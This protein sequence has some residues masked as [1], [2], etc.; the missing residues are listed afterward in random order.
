MNYISLFSGIEAATCAWHPLGW[1]P[2]CFSE[3]EPFPR[4]VLQ[5]HYPDVVLHG[6]M[7]KV[8]WSQYAGQVDV[9]VASA[10]CQAFSVA[11][12]QQSL[13]DDR[14][15]LTLTTIE[16]I[17][18]IR[19]RYFV[20][21][22]VPGLLSTKDN[23]FGCFLAGLVGADK[24]LVSPKKRGR[25]SDAGLV[26]GPQRRAAWR[27]LDAQYFGLAQRRRRVFVVSCPRDGADPQEIL[28]ESTRLS[29]HPPARQEAGEEVTTYTPG[30]FGTYLKGNNIGAT[31]CAQGAS[32]GLGSETLVTHVP[33]VS[34]PTYGAAQSGGFRTTDLDNQ[35]AYVVRALLG[36][37]HRY[38][39]DN[40]L[41]AQESRSGVMT[42]RRLTPL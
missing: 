11:G 38:Q 36:K 5:H 10:P 30:D 39:G 23:A 32:A 6:D 40:I 17:N 35:G 2:T 20:F 16:A 14:G 25:F 21:E 13:D 8:D 7:L 18:A 15:N 22:N 12:L 26:S 29:M 37:G 24:P 41:Q 42:V 31:L 28:F 4:A 19:P 27:V 3:I 33:E 1:T 9:V 34:G